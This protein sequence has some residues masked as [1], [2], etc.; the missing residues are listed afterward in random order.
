MDAL[1]AFTCSL[2]FAPDARAELA[3]FPSVE[4]CQAALTLNAVYSDHLLRCRGLYGSVNG[5][6]LS[7]QLVWSERG[8]YWHQT[9]L[10]ETAELR[11]PWEALAYAWRQAESEADRWMY[12]RRL[13]ALIGEEA[14]HLGRMS[15]VIPIWRFREIE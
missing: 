10:A 3:R 5:A 9:A 7:V 12:L 8:W 6:W 13:R 11:R 1:L 15:P 4:C 2:A 14:W